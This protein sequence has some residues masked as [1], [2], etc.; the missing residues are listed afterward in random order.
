MGNCIKK[1]SS[2]KW[3]GEDWEFMSPAA[4]AINVAGEAADAELSTT[5][6]IREENKGNKISSRSVTEVKIKITKK[7][8]EELLGKVDAR[9]LTVQQILTQLMISG[10]DGYQSNILHRSW[11]PALQSIPEAELY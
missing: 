5:H 10:V 2:T 3:A 1:E 11:R 7:Q 6:L 9:N 8:L 4:G